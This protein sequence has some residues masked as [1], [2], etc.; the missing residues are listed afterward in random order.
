MEEE[1]PSFN[2]NLQF[3]EPQI[4]EE[5]EIEQCKMDKELEECIKEQ[6][7]RT[8][9]KKAELDCKKFMTFIQRK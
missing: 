4:E 3:L 9:V 5:N 2:L 1:N 6:R 7:D 8:T